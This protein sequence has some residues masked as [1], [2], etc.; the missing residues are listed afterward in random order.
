[1]NRWCL[2]LLTFRC[3]WA[4]QAFHGLVPRPAKA[5]VC[6]VNKGNRSDATPGRCALLTGQLYC[7][8][9]DH[10]RMSADNRG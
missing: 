2:H 3:L 8:Q 5:L 9:S 6:G 10:Q 7:K 4:D 1:M